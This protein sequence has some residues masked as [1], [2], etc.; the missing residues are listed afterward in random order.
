MDGHFWYSLKKNND[1]NTDLEQIS[2]MQL[3]RVLQRFYAGVRKPW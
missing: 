1:L 2:A 3:D